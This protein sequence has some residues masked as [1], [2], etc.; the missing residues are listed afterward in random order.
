MTQ[1]ETMKAIAG[2]LLLRYPEKKIDISMAGISK[3]PSCSVKLSAWEEMKI[4]YDKT[5]EL[6]TESQSTWYARGLFGILIANMLKNEDDEY[7]I[8]LEVNHMLN[9]SSEVEI[10]QYI[11]KYN[12]CEPYLRANDKIGCLRGIINIILVILF[13]VVR[14][15]FDLINGDAIK[16]LI[17]FVVLLIAVNIVIS[18]KTKQ[19]RREAARSTI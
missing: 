10:K 11:D 17:G 12:K 14:A 3:R 9:D 5:D 1:S 15:K 19:N 13:F 4:F 7:D 6:D 2:Y 8:W 18:V 16:L